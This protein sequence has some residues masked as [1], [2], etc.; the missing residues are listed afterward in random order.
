MF[1]ALSPLRVVLLIRGE[2]VQ[3]VSSLM[4][5]RTVHLDHLTA[6]WWRAG[7]FVLT[8]ATISEFEEK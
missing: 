2:C 4:N 6:S 7:L 8:G 3:T 1:L 5:G